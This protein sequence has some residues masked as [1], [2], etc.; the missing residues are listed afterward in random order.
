MKK[1]IVLL[2]ASVLALSAAV[3]G[4]GG[5]KNAKNGDGVVSI[6][7]H[8]L[9]RFD[10]AD[11]DSVWS[12]I[13]EQCGVKL[14]ISGAPMNGYNEKINLMVNNFEAP[15]IFFYLP[16]NSD[17]YYK[18][19][20]E[21]MMVDLAEYVKDD[22][23]YPNLY[24]LFYNDAYK[25]LT[26]DGKHT[27]VP[28]LS[29]DCNWGI[30][31]RQDWLD[32]LGLS[33]PKTLQELYDV[34]YAFTYN[35]PDGNGKNDTY[36]IGGSTE[37]YW[38]MPIYAA[39]QAQPDWNYSKDKTTMEYMTFTDGFKDFVTY[40]K[41]CYD[42]GLVIKDFYTKTDDMKIEDFA[43]GKVGI[44]I[45][46]G[47]EHVQNIMQ[48]TSQASPHAVVDVLDMIE[49][50]AGKNIHGWGGW[51]GGYSISADSSDIPAALKVLDYLVSEEGSMARY[52]GI[53]DTH[54]TMQ[55]DKVMITEENAANRTAEGADRFSVIKVDGKEYPY[56][57]Y[58]WGPWFGSLY[59]FEGNKIRTY[60]D[61]SYYQWADLAQKIATHINRSVK[62][63]D[64][65]N[66]AVNDKEFSSIMN[67]L[68]D[69]AST[70]IINAIVG[71]KNV[72]SDW[73]AYIEEANKLGYGTA[74]KKAYSIM[75]EL[76]GDHEK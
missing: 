49:G 48:K 65:A 19:A 66:I 63:A 70:Y 41:G 74:Q 44:L 50:P 61:C 11:K 16:E 40:M 64:M 54:Y 8:D 59:R 24:K 37:Y 29:P 26:Y 15:D 67:L 72:D 36:G 38:F 56:G 62:M 9:D 28:R 43:T 23:K 3:T 58:A 33:Q 12:Y 47:G 25:N 27:L 34:M 52:Y 76:G 20:Q 45:H 7:S 5:K 42:N 53:K 71:E 75:Q 35:D 18:W 46:N 6:F 2:L 10:G 60:D 32:N 31:V 55:D 57:A 4:C 17:T 21:D 73:N 22:S 39:Y 30:Y 69:H 68:D 13:E 1:K 51:W 14:E